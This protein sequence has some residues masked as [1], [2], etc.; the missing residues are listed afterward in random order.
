MT[1]GTEIF[2]EKDGSVYH[3][4]V[5]AGEVAPRIVTV[6]PVERAELLSTLLKNPGRVASGRG[7]V[8]FTG[9]Y[10]GTLCSIISVGMGS[11]MVDFML[12]ETTHLLPSD[13]M[14]VIRVGTC[15]VLGDV[16]KPGD[17]IIA[18]GGSLCSYRDYAGAAPGG[19]V[20]YVLAGPEPCDEKLTNLLQKHL[21][22]SGAP[23]RCGLNA[24][25]MSFFDCQ[26]KISEHFDDGNEGV[27]EAMVKAGALSMDMET[28]QLFFQAN[29]RKAPTVAAA[30]HIARQHAAADVM[31][32]RALAAGKAAL[33]A[34]VETQV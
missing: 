3:L 11:S 22:S 14:A 27:R 13:P 31:T 23:I 30:C 2:L 28:H 33:E 15:G 6:G 5:K 25:G 26:G 19:V 1:I 32:E 12:R 29:R 7:F 24:S 9:T 20:P 34:L 18:K 21:E 10:K 16:A 8:T 17:I 4:G